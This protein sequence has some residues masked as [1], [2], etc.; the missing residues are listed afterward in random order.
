M[1]SGSTG[2][3]VGGKTGWQDSFSDSELTFSMLSLRV[4]VP[5]V[6]GIWIG[7][8]FLYLVTRTLRSRT[9]GGALPEP[10]DAVGARPG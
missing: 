7:W 10:R 5:T 9:A 8:P 4:P 3:W 6:E 1:S 2:A